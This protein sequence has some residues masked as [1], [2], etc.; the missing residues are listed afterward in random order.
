MIE[1]AFESFEPYEQVAFTRTQDAGA[2]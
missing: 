1:T 2:D